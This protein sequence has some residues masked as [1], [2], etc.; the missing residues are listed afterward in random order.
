MQGCVTGSSGN[1][2]IFSITDL[3]CNIDMLPVQC[4][5]EYFAGWGPALSDAFA[6]DRGQI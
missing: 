2:L 3:S 1:P 4:M 5:L 6:M